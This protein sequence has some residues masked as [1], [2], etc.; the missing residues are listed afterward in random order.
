MKCRIP[1]PEQ[2][3]RAKQQIR[4][5]RQQHPPRP[6]DQDAIIQALE[7]PRTG[8]FITTNLYWD[9]ECDPNYIRPAD[10]RM[11]ENCGMLQEESPQSRI[12]ELRTLGIHIDLDHPNIITSLAEHSILSRKPSAKPEGNDRV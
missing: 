2:V 7:F 8:Y 4:E 6:I 12:N 1:N 11:C 5:N 9:C 3:R 10:M